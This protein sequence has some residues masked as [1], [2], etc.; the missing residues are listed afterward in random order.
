MNG[1]HA[2]AAIGLL[3]VGALRAQ[4]EPPKPVPDPCQA[5]IDAFIGV[6]PRDPIALRSPEVRRALAP[7]AL[8]VLR[9]IRDFAAAQTES[10]L[11]RRVHEFVI[12]AAVFDE[13]GLR[14]NL[15]ERGRNGDRDAELL[16]SS[17]A[18]IAA[19]DG[20]GRTRAID[21]CAAALRDAADDD[22]KPLDAN[23]ASCAV[24]CL[25]IA[26]GLSEAEAR[27]LGGRGVAE[28]VATRLL[29]IAERAAR[30]PARLLGLPLELE[31]SLVD[32]EVFRLSSLRGKVVLVDFWASWCAPCK[33]AL[34][35]LVALR[36]EFAGKGFEVVGISCDREAAALQAFLKAHP[37]VDWPQL[38]AGEGVRWHPLATRFGVERIPRMFLVDRGGILRS[39]DAGADLRAQVQRYLRE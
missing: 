2:L 9:R 24:Q 18:V 37:E 11:G 31:G 25:A 26:A 32:G 3:L 8:P 16:R 21:A 5:L 7:R 33:K 28:P 34:P 27:K 39:V 20:D 1:A 13:P 6:M 19:V 14:D 12:Y 30:D 23:V 38:F 17:A 29:E 4:D 36:A 10:L 22:A 15:A 35:D